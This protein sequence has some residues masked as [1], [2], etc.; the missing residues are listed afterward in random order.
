[1]V[2]D[3]TDPAFRPDAQ[4]DGRQRERR[5][6]GRMGRAL[7]IQVLVLLLVVLGGCYPAYYARG[8]YGPSYSSHYCPYGYRYYGYGHHGYYYG[9]GGYY[10]HYHHYYGH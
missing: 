1:M 4:E 7:V 10:G 5:A 3:V 6:G 8:D 2:S 9:H